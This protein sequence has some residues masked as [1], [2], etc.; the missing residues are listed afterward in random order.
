M[1]VLRIA[2]NYMYLN[3]FPKKEPSYYLRYPHNDITTF[4]NSRKVTYTYYRNQILMTKDSQL[5]NTTASTWD[6]V[7][8][9]HPELFV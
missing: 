4:N 3:V 9:L 8:Q 1:N 2:G 7:R 5:I 6:E